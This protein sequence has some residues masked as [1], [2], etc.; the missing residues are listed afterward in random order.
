[1]SIGGSATNRLFETEWLVWK[2]LRHEERVRHIKADVDNKEPRVHRHLHTRRKAEINNRVR[3]VAIEKENHR[4]LQRI[5][6]IMMHQHLDNNNLLRPR[7]VNVP[8]RMMQ[9]QRILID[10]QN[11]LQRLRKL[12]PVYDH[13]EWKEHWARHVRHHRRRLNITA[14]RTRVRSALLRGAS[15]RQNK[16]GAIAYTSRQE[17]LEA[18]NRLM[19][20]PKS[21][22]ANRAESAASASSS[23]R[24]A[25]RSQSAMIHSELLA[26]C[27][28]QRQGGPQRGSS[29]GPTGR[30]RRP[31][32]PPSGADA[33]NRDP[34][35]AAGAGGRGSRLV[36]LRCATGEGRRPTGG[37]SRGS[38]RSSA[39]AAEYDDVDVRNDSGPPSPASS[40]PSS[41]SA[42][43]SAEPQSK[44]SVAI[45]KEGCS[46]GGQ[47]CVVTVV[48]QFYPHQLRFTAVNLETSKSDS[49]T[50]AFRDVYRPVRREEP[51]LLQPGRRADLVRQ[52]LQRL[53]F[54]ENT[55]RLLFDGARP[56]PAPPAARRPHS[57]PEG[58]GDGDDDGAAGEDVL[59]V[60]ISV[61]CRHLPR[62]PLTGR[63]DPV[64]CFYVFDDET[65]EFEFVGQTEVQSATAGPDF[66]R[67]FLVQHFARDSQRVR[68]CVYDNSR[69]AASVE[70]DVAS[71]NGEFEPSALLGYV[72]MG[73]GQLSQAA[74]EDRPLQLL[75]KKSGRFVTDDKGRD[76]SIVFSVGSVGGGG[77]SQGDLYG[78]AAPAPARRSA[79]GGG[80][81]EDGA[82][83]GEAEEA[84]R[85]SIMIQ[86]RG[87]PAIPSRR[88]EADIGTMEVPRPVVAL[89]V[90]DPETN[91]FMYAGQT[92]AAPLQEVRAVDEDGYDD[93]SQRV[94]ECNV[95]R[96]QFVI[97]HYLSGEE[98]VR[99]SVF[100]MDTDADVVDV[101]KEQRSYIGHVVVPLNEFVEPLETE[102]FNSIVCPVLYRNKLVPSGGNG[103][104]SSGNAQMI[105]TCMRYENAPQQ[106][107]WSAARRAA[108]EQAEA[109]AEAEAEAGERDGGDIDARAEAEDLS[110]DEVEAEAEARALAEAEADREMRALAAAEEEA[111]A[112]IQAE[113]EA[114]EAEAAAAEAAAAEAAAAEAAAA[115]AVAAAASV[116]RSLTI[117]LS[118]ASLPKK[119]FLSKSDPLA[120]VYVKTVATGADGQTKTVYDLV[121]QTEHFQNEANPKFATPVTLADVPAD[122]DRKLKICVY[123]VDDNDSPTQDD[124]LGSA[125]VQTAHLDADAGELE[126]TLLDK[127]GEPANKGKARVTLSY[128]WAA[129]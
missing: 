39:A 68:F 77:G 30:R 43:A 16:R 92:E 26:A 118:C 124:M 50:A 73:F 31:R 18:S 54:H 108:F 12:R 125:V 126:L 52:M 46:I 101:P 34:N 60:D 80:G 36:P 86:C 62:D 67:R 100:D 85:I 102:P 110:R 88:P 57:L 55:G 61:G 2:Q 15:S 51:E 47:Y 89:Y 53:S 96:R 69:V 28:E 9:Q 8:A 99:F 13:R 79:V 105:L 14:I 116:P 98:T 76:S 49:V 7:S 75:L 117:R 64:V 65:E 109:E 127:K 6:H 22:Q 63:V 93:P 87:L 74:A 45:A 33:E 122:S 56:V 37:A 82:S 1:M 44:P 70:G 42:S 106:S 25:Q 115:E 4:L 78:G 111:A 32:R 23:S 27:K 128:T 123:D 41:A 29:A 91:D 129:Q 81:G 120:A 20:P 58:A 3:F 94:F 38:A 48:E 103:T 107:A 114:A 5:A 72:S 83:D 104:D 113:A 40:S 121:G 10:N 119:D 35:S 59:E 84:Q 19:H 112:R 66:A 21:K 17:Q 71:A 11:I 95:F 97:D 24:R 90:R